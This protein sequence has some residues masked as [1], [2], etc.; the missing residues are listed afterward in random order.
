[1][2]GVVVERGAIAGCG[3]QPA[4]EWFRAIVEIA[5][6]GLGL[7]DAKVVVC[8]ANPWLAERIGRPAEQLVGISVLH[9]LDPAGQAAARAGLAA[10]APAGPTVTCW[11]I[12]A[13]TGI[14]GSCR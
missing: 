14:R 12:A 4:A 2:V 13:R 7:V 3:R 10:A 5:G 1:M 9:L 11:S 6:V 8:Y